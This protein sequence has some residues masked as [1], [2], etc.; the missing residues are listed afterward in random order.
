IELKHGL[1]RPLKPSWLYSL[2]LA[3]AAASRLH[4]SRAPIIEKL[5]PFDVLD[6]VRRQHFSH[7]DQLAWHRALAAHGRET[8]LLAVALALLRPQDGRGREIRSK[9]SY[10][11]GMLRQSRGALN[12]VA[13]LSSLLH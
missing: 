5:D 13:S 6:A 1:S 10:L 3:R 4:P 12:P 9:A 11:G 8:A 2:A 7:F